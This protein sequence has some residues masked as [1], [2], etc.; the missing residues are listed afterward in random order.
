MAN[1][2]NVDYFAPREFSDPDAMSQE[3]IEKLDTARAF[4]EVPFKINSSYREGDPLAHG[5]GTAVDIS[6][7][8]SVDR[9]DMLKA[10][11]LVG[12]NRIGVYDRHIHV[13]VDKE[14]PQDVTWWGKSK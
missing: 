8:K 13:D 10:L 12:F 4:A 11:Y 6:C 7:T 9:H 5:R 2:Q 1:F 14:L 3:L